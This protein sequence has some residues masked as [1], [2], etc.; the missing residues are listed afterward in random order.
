MSE[1]KIY[2]KVG[3][4]YHEIGVCDLE[5]CYY[6]HGAHLVISRKGST[7]TKLN[8]TPAHAAIEVALQSVRDVMAKA[9]A[10]ATKIAPEKRP[11]TK[12]ERDGIA[13]MRAIV[14]DMTQIRFEGLSMQDVVEAGIK[15]LAAEV[16][17]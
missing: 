17:A 14:G 7:L 9:M 11:Y 15:I 5:A 16:K 8:V 10:D 2:K 4:R 1:E 3:R 12:R 6:P 13:A